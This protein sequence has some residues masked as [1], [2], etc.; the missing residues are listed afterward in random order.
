M[1][2]I[3]REQTQAGGQDLD[4]LAI[5]TALVLLS[6]RSTGML[7][8]FLMKKVLADVHLSLP[9]VGDT[10]MVGMARGDATITEIKAA[11]EMTQRER[12]MTQQASVREVLWETVRMLTDE[13][14]YVR[15][16]ESIGGGKG[17]P[18]EDGDGWQWFAY[19]MGDNAQVGGAS[20]VISATEYGVWL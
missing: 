11:M 19:N 1:V 9:D 17:I 10:I 8:S 16:V 2:E 7:Q 14:P 13:V 4:T 12:D 20:V 18:F 5:N 3:I 6:G 15:I